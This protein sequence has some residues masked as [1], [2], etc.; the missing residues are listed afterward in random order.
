M[1]TTTM[2]TDSGSYGDND[3]ECYGTIEEEGQWRQRRALFHLYAPQL[4]PFLG[5]IREYLEGGE[6]S[7]PPG[8]SGT[9][10]FIN[11]FDK[12]LFMELFSV[13][14]MAKAKA[15]GEQRRLVDEAQAKLEGSDDS[16]RTILYNPEDHSDDSE[17]TIPY[18]Q[19]ILRRF[20]DPVV[21]KELRRFIV[22]LHEQR[23]KQKRGSYK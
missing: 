4:C 23:K 2:A 11:S 17:R 7:I 15:E 9:T 14:R 8:T 5:Y 12:V 3:N 21:K 1:S 20:T 19:P 18:I 22:E 13:E 10:G 6:I 16:Q